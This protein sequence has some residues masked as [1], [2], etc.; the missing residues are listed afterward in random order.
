MPWQRAFTAGVLL[1]AAAISNDADALPQR[2][3]VASSGADTNTCAI[4]QPCRS[5]ASAIA[6]T[7]AGGEVIVLD[8]AGYGP[9]T[10]TQSVSII[11]PPGVYAG[12]TAFPGNVGVIVNAGPS[13]KIVLR[14]LSIIGQGGMHGIIVD[15]AGEV[16]VENCV[17][18]NMT[19]NGIFVFLATGNTSIRVQN[20]S[21]RSNGGMGLL[22]SG[23]VPAVQVVDSQFVLNGY[24]GT[25]PPPGGISVE[26]GTFSAQRIVVDGNAGNGIAALADGTTTVATVEDSLISGN[27][28]LGAVVNTSPLG[29]S[30]SLTVVRSTVARNGAGG[31]WTEATVAAAGVS[32][33]VSDSAI[34]ENGGAG[35]LATGGD[36]SVLVTRSTIA[37]NAGPDF[38]N[39]AGIFLSSGNNTLTGR[40]PSDIQGTITSNP[41]K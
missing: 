22:V 21:V 29:G 25:F 18:A 19:G 34:T 35:A 1:L 27:G 11:A 3:F 31:L 17:V 26:T 38:S 24:A 4:T 23:G 10:I 32:L 14:G 16:H 40:G 36:S 13:D 7:A 20:T 39:T 5:F 37:R 30:A 15:A 33:V 8:S 41:P 28:H 2:T 6:L 12:I 9:V